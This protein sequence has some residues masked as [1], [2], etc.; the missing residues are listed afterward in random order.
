MRL[1]ELL[2]HA[3]D[4]LDENRV[5]LGE[6]A[7]EVDDILPVV[8]PLVRLSVD[9]TQPVATP[10]ALRLLTLMETEIAPEGLDD[11]QADVADVVRL[12]HVVTGEAQRAAQ[13]IAQAGI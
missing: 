1:P 4:H 3:I 5:V 9:L 6:L 7:E 10:F 2:H 11:V 12:Q 8:Q 13:G